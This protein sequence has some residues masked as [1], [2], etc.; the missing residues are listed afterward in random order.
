MALASDTS[1]ADAAL[2]VVMFSEA[3]EM[4]YKS[5]EAGHPVYEDRD[6]IEIRVPGDGLNIVRREISDADRERFPL[7]WKRYQELR[8]PTT[9]PG[10]PV[11][12]WPAISRSVAKNLRAVGFDV[13][14]QI[15]A[16]SDQN[17]H[18]LGMMCGM[19]PE[20][21]RD[22]AKAF[23]AAAQDTALVQKQ[24]QEM[25]ELRQRNTDL[26][27]EVKRIS[28]AFEAMQKKHKKE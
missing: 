8:Q 26:A 18:R 2:N 23:L 19:Q 22:K 21:F 27:A 3:V 1:N 16:A 15:A 25:A 10:C 28:D 20:A 7:H 11:E 6:F 17:I 12:E 4:P 24:A 13:V 14:E 9:N 5:K